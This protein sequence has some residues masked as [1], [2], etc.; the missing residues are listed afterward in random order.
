[1][2]NDDIFAE[3][4]SPGFEEYLERVDN[5]TT[6]DEEQEEFYMRLMQRFCLNVYEGKPVDPWILRAFADAFTKILLGGDWC[7]EIYLPW[8]PQTTIRSRADQRDLE[9]YCEVQNAINEASMANPPK[10][11][12]TTELIRIAASKHC[13]SYEIARDAYYKL[14]KKL[15]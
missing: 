5:R 11:L 6:S 1:M 9:I 14:R 3:G 7:D 2:A 10:K 15:S 12:K 13:C 8:I 4:R